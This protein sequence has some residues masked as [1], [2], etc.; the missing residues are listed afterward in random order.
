MRILE[1]TR[2]NLSWTLCLLFLG[3]LSLTKAG[4]PPAVL[5]VTRGSLSGTLRAL[6]AAVRS[7]VTSGYGTAELT[8]RKVK[9]DGDGRLR[10]RLLLNFWFSD[11]QCFWRARDQA[12]PHKFV[13]ATLVRNGIVVQYFPGNGHVQ[14]GVFGE[15][16]PNV[17]VDRLGAFETRTLALGYPI[18]WTYRSITRISPLDIDRHDWRFF[19]QARHWTSSFPNAPSPT[20]TIEKT[21]DFLTIR[22]KWHRD[23]K[24]DIIGITRA[25][26][27]DLAM[28][29]MVSRW[30]LRTEQASG[31]I[32]I[33]QSSTIVTAWRD[34]D[35][36][37][38]PRKRVIINRGR[39]M[40]KSGIWKPAGSLRTVIKFI[41]FRS[42]RV[43]R[44]VF[45]IANL[46]V[47]AGSLVFD[48]VHRSHYA[49]RPSDANRLLGRE[50]SATTTGSVGGNR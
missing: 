19:S 30:Q 9:F 41:K 8:L 12:A 26:T 40:G 31:G 46:H 21:G 13:G 23:P 25:S 18:S 28:G 36:L 48:N 20:T 42:A 1:G 22:F 47:L 6:R 10:R 34:V 5:G 15:A 27:F 14:N 44:S 24:Y 33:K 16:S 29:G 39:N 45:T 38:F 11:N 2:A 37:Y 32:R 49:Y 17:R 50:G 35:G 43:N 7:R 3:A 4:F